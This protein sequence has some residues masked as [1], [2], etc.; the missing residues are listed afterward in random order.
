MTVPHVTKK[1]ISETSKQLASWTKVC[2]A[3][4]VQPML[5]WEEMGNVVP[6]KNYDTLAENQR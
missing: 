2:T 3:R 1:T 4:T 6:Y 5:E